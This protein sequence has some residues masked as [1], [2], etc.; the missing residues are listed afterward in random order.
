MTNDQA[1]RQAMNKVFSDVLDDIY[2]S[3]R[4]LRGLARDAERQGI[5]ELAGVAD[6]ICTGIAEALAKVNRETGEDF[7]N[8]P[9][10]VGGD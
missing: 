9:K 8:L 3:T 10:A 2:S 1:G 7:K 4:Q 5:P 6:R